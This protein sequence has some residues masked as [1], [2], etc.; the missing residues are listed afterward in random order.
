MVC[1]YVNETLKRQDIR[2]HRYTRACMKR[3]SFDAEIAEI[4]NFTNKVD[5]TINTS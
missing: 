1:E 2:N 4:A 5:V 3:N